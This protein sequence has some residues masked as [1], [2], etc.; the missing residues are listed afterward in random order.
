[1]PVL[2]EY[3]EKYG[4]DFR[5]LAV[6][7]DEPPEDVKVFVN[8]L[9][10]TFDILLD[11]GGKVV[12]LYRVR[13]FPSTFFVDADGIIRYQHIGILSETQLAGYLEHLGVLE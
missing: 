12:D 11:P 10:L 13:A 8:E 1:M 7:L 5:I 4:P 6:N 9:S 2:Q 3:H